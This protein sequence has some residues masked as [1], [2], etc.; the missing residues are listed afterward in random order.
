MCS[1]LDSREKNRKRQNRP[2]GQDPEGRDRQADHIGAQTSKE[3]KMTAQTNQNRIQLA[4]RDYLAAGFAPIPVER[5][6]KAP[7]LRGWPRLRIDK[8]Q[9][10]DYFVGSENVGI[11]LGK[12]SRGLVDVDLDVSE[13]AAIADVFLPPTEM[14]H[15]R[16]SK[17][18][19]H[20]WYRVENAPAPMKFTDADGICLLEIR[21]R[22][23]QTLVPPSIHPSGERIRWEEDGPPAKVQ[24]SELVRTAKLVAASALLARNWPE[25]GS[26]NETAL[27]LAGMLQRAG[28]SLEETEA[29]I[30]TTA[31]AAGDEQ[32]KERV[33]A[34]RSTKERLAGKAEAT[35][36]TRLAKAAP[37]PKD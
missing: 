2:L 28:W 15:G 12:P 6:G 20:R 19:S 23:Q 13:A 1:S 10:D 5:G 29:F 22:G 35:G 14:V 25:R 24:A 31:R 18:R 26:R 9:I 21:S 11:L 17:P 8:E 7:T 30:R 16:K 27:A 33:T 34:A 4:V 37:I 36:A 32:Y 3:A